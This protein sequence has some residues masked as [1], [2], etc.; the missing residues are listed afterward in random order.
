MEDMAE[1]KSVPPTS[2]ASVLGGGE[3]RSAETPVPAAP[4]AEAVEPAVEPTA[5]G[6]GANTGPKVKTRQDWLSYIHLALVSFS[7][8]SVPRRGEAQGCFTRQDHA[9]G[10]A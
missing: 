8:P 9:L 3:K 4:E 5:G 2:P 1:A 10:E 7:F 6:G